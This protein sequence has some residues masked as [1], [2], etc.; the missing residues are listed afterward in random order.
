MTAVS[1]MDGKVTYDMQVA[2]TPGRIATQTIDMVSRGLPGGGATMWSTERSFE[3]TG[4]AH[5]I[6]TYASLTDALDAAR[7]LS[8]GRNPG[9]A[10]MSWRGGYR[11][12]DVRTTS[13][14][15]FSNSTH[16]PWPPVTRETKRS[17]VPFSAGNIRDEN[18]TSNP[19]VARDSHLIALVDGGQTWRVDANQTWGGAPRLVRG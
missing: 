19:A 1:H 8:E 3:L 13:R 15:Y 9:V 16:S 17:N 6:A 4:S 18:R 14:T 7:Q 11:L 2:A 12:H 5:G 10:V